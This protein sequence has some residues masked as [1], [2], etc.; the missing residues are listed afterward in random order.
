VNYRDFI[1]PIISNLFVPSKD[2]NGQWWYRI[3]SSRFNAFGEVDCLDAFNCVPE[4]NAVINMKA[5]ARSNGRFKVVDDAGKE[6]PNEPI[7]TLLKNPN[8][9]Q[10]GKE[11]I[12]QSTLF[13]EIYGNEIPIIHLC[14]VGICKSE[15]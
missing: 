11:F 14:I 15:E 5:N 12:K 13:H 7:L 1:P 8:W 6:Y 9:F 10:A 4:V 3:A 2:E